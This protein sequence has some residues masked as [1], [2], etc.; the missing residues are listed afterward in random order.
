MFP[1]APPISARSEVRGYV[2]EKMKKIIAFGITIFNDHVITYSRVNF[3]GTNFLG[4]NGIFEK[5][6]CKLFRDKVE[7]GLP[8]KYSNFFSKIN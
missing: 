6:Y 2:S 3:L 4:T 5:N 1:V 8:N 7:Y